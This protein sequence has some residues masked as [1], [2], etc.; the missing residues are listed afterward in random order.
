MGPELVSDLIHFPRF[1][2]IDT[3]AWWVRFFKRLLIFLDN[4]LAVRLMIQLWLVPVWQDTTI[5]GRGLSFTF[6]TV[7]VVIGGII[8]SA[9][10]LAAVFW[11][12]IW[13]LL[14]MVLL[15]YTPWSLAVFLLVWIIDAALQVVVRQRDPALTVLRQAQADVNRL[16][17]ELV[18]QEDVISLLNSIEQDGLPEKSLSV[19]LEEVMRLSEKERKQAGDENLRVEHLFLGV[20]SLL[21]FHH[22]QA[23]RAYAWMKNKRKWAKTPWIWGDD[24]PVRPIGGVNRGWTGIITPEL[25][26]VSTDLTQLAARGKI[27]ELVGR[28]GQVEE[29]VRI[30]GREGRENV[31]LI[32]EAGTGKTT[33]VR[34]L[35]NEIVRGT[36]YAG[37]RFKR[38]IA[39]DIAALSA[40]SMGKLKE[41][42]VTIIDEIKAAG[43]IM[44]F[45]DEIASIIAAEEGQSASVVFAALEPHLDAGEFQFIATT[46]P[47]N[48]KR[49]IEPSEAFSRTFRVITI[50]EASPKEVEEILKWKAFELE[51]RH[52]ITIT[53]SAIEAT[54]ELSRRYIHD[55][56]LP[57]SAIDLLE[58]TVA[59]SAKE[60]KTVRTRDVEEMVTEKTKIPVRA[61]ESEK[62]KAILLNLEKELHKRIVGQDK[63]VEELA[64][65]LRRARTGMAEEGR[66]L[67][68]FLFAGATGVGK[69]ETAKALAQVYF[70]SE[71]AMVRLDM[72]EFQTPDSINRLIGPPPG[73]PG[74]EQGGQLT[75]AIRR[76]P[77]TVILLD[78]IEKANPRILDVFLQLLDDARLTDG[79]GRTVDFANTMVIATSNVGTKAIFKGVKEGKET[80]ALKQEV[81]TAIREKFRPEFLNRFTG[82]M[83]FQPL[84]KEQID[85]ITQM[86]LQRLKKTMKKKEIVIEFSDELVDK[87]RKKGFSEEWGAR[88][89]RRVIRDEVEEKIAKKILQGKLKPGKRYLL[90][91]KFLS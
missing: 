10:A 22:G 74:F 29:M 63:A 41:R 23:Q 28:E 61:A 32:G 52:N 43:N 78:E 85:E 2:Y 11:V 4:Q 13:L 44:L 46:T 53:Y 70:G 60:K 39:L 31:M 90:T 6:R 73:R 7:R 80:D 55:R 89:L 88:E 77:F 14:P 64:D 72:S 57:D 66:V 35:A 30:L 1:W 81:L 36:E 26:K 49:F 48:H 42:L 56:F 19:S 84:S 58:E 47:S 38:L 83:V 91:P 15:V 40:G 62:E 27:P 59:K 3:P 69:T 67:A 21:K 9:T 24:Y 51:Q 65:A 25:D 54:V 5:I 50:P 79:A 68:S 17:K 12:L 33:L 76:R 18:Q 20:L 71:K 8:I 75:E 34:A 82:I 45:V 16:R 87:V 37:L 86:L